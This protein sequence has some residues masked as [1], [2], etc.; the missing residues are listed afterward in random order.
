M[1]YFTLLLL[2]FLGVA[3][4]SQP[5]APATCTG[6]I[7]SPANGPQHYLSITW[8]SVGAATS[9]TLESSPDGAT[10]GTLSSGSNITTYS[11]D[12]SD[13]G[14]VPFY[15]RVAAVNGSGTSA[16]TNCTPY[17]LYTAC[18]TPALPVV[19]SAGATSVTV[20]LVP[21]S[22]TPNATGTTYAIYCATTG[23]Y[24]QTNGVLGANPAW[25]TMAAWG[26]ITVTGLTTGTSYCFYAEAM[27]ENG[28]IRTNAG[29]TLLATQY[30]NTSNTLYTGNGSTTTLWYSPATCTYGGMT[31]QSTGGCSGGTGGGCVGY[32]QSPTS[33]GLACFLRSPLLNCAGMS[34]VTMTFDLTNT[35]STLG[36]SVYF[37][38]WSNGANNYFP[39]CST[40][41]PLVA[42]S[43]YLNVARSCQFM[44]V[45]FNLSSIPLADRSQ[46][47]FYLNPA[48][49]EATGTPF[50][51]L[52]DNITFLGQPDAECATPTACTAASISTNPANSTVCVGS[53]TSF[54]IGTSGSVAG[55]QWQV[56]TNG[57]SSWTNVTNGGVYSNATT[58]SLTI[59][60]VTAGMNGY[61][62]RDSITGTCGGNGNSQAATLA[63]LN[64]PS[65]AGT[66]TGTATVCPGQNNVTY[67]ITA[68]SGATGYN[69]S[70]PAGATIVG[71][72]GTTSITVDYSI[73]AT[74]GDIVVTPTGTCGSG[75]ASPALP[76]T[77][78]QPP[79]EPGP[80][81][82]DTTPC[83]GSE[84]V[85]FVAPDNGAIS[86]M[87][88]LPNGW[89]GT[90][91]EDNIIVTTG[92]NSGIISITA[93]NTCGNSATRTLTVAVDSAPPMPG[94]ISGPNPA[95]EGGTAIYSV[96]SVNGAT[97]YTW[98]VP[99]G[100]SG[101]ST[102][103]SIE[104][105]AGASGGTISVTADNTCGNSSPE[106]L[107]VSVT[108]ALS[109]PGVI[110]GPDSLCSG[111]TQAYSIAPVN[112]ATSYTWTLPTGWTGSS[113][114]NIINVTA[115]TGTGNISVS[116]NSS[117]GSS[118]AQTLTVTAKPLPGALSPIAGPTTICAGDSAV[119]SVMPNANTNYYDWTLPNGWTGSSITDSINT[120]A[121]TTG[122]NIS[123][124]AYNGCGSSAVQTTDITV[125]ALPQPG[126]TT[127]DSIICANDSA[128]VCAVG[129]FAGYNWNTGQTTAC[130]YAKAAGNYYVT[131]TDANHCQAQ[132]GQQSIK[133]YAVPSVSI[134]VQGDT[135]SSYGAVYY[136]WYLNDTAIPNANSSLFIAHVVGNYTLAITDTNGCTAISS[137][138][139]ITFITTGITN[140]TGQG[141]SV[142]PNPSAGS[143]QLQAGSEF[144]GSAIEIYDEN[145]RIIYRSVL[146]N[147]HSQI[148][149]DYAASGIYLLK[150]IPMNSEPVIRKLIKAGN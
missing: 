115:G 47:Y 81:S 51:V 73:T 48:F 54:T 150:I 50:N 94:V 109:N 78:N 12:A 104:A 98:V 132:S 44:T 101:S 32:T 72:S 7:G 64:D 42:S 119:Y 63:I 80:I 136:Q 52:F 96:A 93:V 122:G 62:Y 8:S 35:A 66:I 102:T 6:T 86:F 17:P 141:V 26:T 99:S 71:G 43:V 29:N 117:C 39:D 45:V 75:A 14:N 147:T 25:Q 144:I 127:S 15:Y 33:Y 23:Q 4:F 120:I 145:G 3:A 92:S 103:N 28:D 53:N 36:D 34:T 9:Y 85:Y 74:G 90:S 46:L 5:A 24:V 149:L 95:C 140:L 148:D 2:V 84:Q 131:V 87:W 139:N 13:Q 69:W 89:T 68:V 105:G 138:V 56:S 22:P 135:L 38:I 113:A 125:N 116:A 79:S 91:T 88:S 137:V 61:Q 11:Y 128:Q 27:N 134:I 126:I 142:Y 123:V 30:F 112:N 83:S 67:S 107:N 143:W 1:R 114:S 76:I 121:G 108:S 97:S 118:Q 124:T 16:Y 60:G 21:E 18:D 49:Y 130:I 106:T 111:S 31:W 58:S 37:D 41:P 65:A 110:S 77:V 19:T 40:C 70:V 59:T 57:G 10:W 100:W 20:Q 82:G 129:N 133:V 55:Y 146:S